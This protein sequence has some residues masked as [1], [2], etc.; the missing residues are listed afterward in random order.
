MWTKEYH[1]KKMAIP[2]A[3]LVN[4]LA[5]KGILT[6]LDDPHRHDQTLENIVFLGPDRYLKMSHHSFYGYSRIACNYRHID[7]SKV[8][9]VDVTDEMYLNNYIK[10]I[11]EKH[12]GI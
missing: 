2:V 10:P 9:I 1:K 11:I 6:T 8:E 7:D 3:K 4:Y 5:K 12:F